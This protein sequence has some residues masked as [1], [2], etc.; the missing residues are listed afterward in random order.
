M[1]F[2]ATNMIENGRDDKFADWLFCGRQ[3]RLAPGCATAADAGR[4]ASPQGDFSFRSKISPASTGLA[5]PLESFITWP[6]R[7]FNAAVLPDW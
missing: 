3:G 1:K 4:D 5:L 2:I 6:L 7:E